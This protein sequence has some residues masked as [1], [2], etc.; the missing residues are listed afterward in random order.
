MES[1][2]LAGA[3]KSQA[4]D[5]EPGQTKTKCL[6]KS[7]TTKLL[8]DR[9]LSRANRVRGLTAESGR[10]TIGATGL[11][12]DYEPET[13][14]GRDTGEVKT[15]MGTYMMPMSR[16]YQSRSAEAKINA[17]SS[18]SNLEDLEEVEEEVYNS[19]SGENDCDEGNL[20]K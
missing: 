2:Q 7:S 12:I 20:T 15:E 4:R 8:E 5:D 9:Y 14:V 17:V 11:S 6:Q 19:G 13:L 1:L 10:R 3:G 18:F 16:P